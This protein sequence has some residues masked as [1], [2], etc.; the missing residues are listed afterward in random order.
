[1]RIRRSDRS[2]FPCQAPDQKVTSGQR[3]RLFA[4]QTAGSPFGMAQG[5]C[6]GC[7]QAR[8]FRG[9]RYPIE[10]WP[11][12]MVR[13]GGLPQGRGERERGG[14]LGCPGS[15]WAWWYRLAPSGSIAPTTGP[16]GGEVPPVQQPGPGGGH[17]LGRQS[18]SSWGEA[19]PAAAQ[20]R[21]AG[22]FKNY[23]YGAVTRKPRVSPVRGPAAPVCPGLAARD[24][25][26]PARLS[27]SVSK[28]ASAGRSSRRPSARLGVPG[29]PGAGARSDVPARTLNIPSA[30]DA[31]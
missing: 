21:P 8:T 29:M 20:C 5:V 25:N 4:Q 14:Y 12:H 31:S 6:N 16:R 18:V 1:M 26:S 27:M 9:Y 17:K 13:G 7:R 10:L 23:R 15:S 22:L 19:R 28:V 3:P 2:G 30:P 11:A 24:S